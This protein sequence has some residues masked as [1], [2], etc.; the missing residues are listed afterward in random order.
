M[1]IITAFR[2]FS[3]RVRGLIVLSASQWVVAAML[4]TISVVAVHWGS[5]TGMVWDPRSGVIWNVV[6]DGPAD[7]AGIREG[8]RLAAVDDEPITSGLPPFYDVAPWSN[9]DL[10]VERDGR[11][12]H[13]DLQTLTQMEMRQRGFSEGSALALRSANEYIRIAVNIWILLLSGAILYLR[14][15]HAQARVASVA[16][17]Y[18]VGGNALLEVPGFGHLVAPL[19]DPLVLAIHFIDIVFFTGFLALFVHF[20]LIFPQPLPAV[21]QHK[22]IQ[23]VP[24]LIALPVVALS[25]FR[26]LRVVE[27]EVRAMLPAIQIDALMRIYSPGMLLASISIL[28]LH[29]RHEP[30]ET[31]R[32]RLRWVLSAQIPPFASWVLLLSLEAVQPGVG[33]VAIGRTIFWVGVAAGSLIFV[34]AILKHR[35]FETRILLR[36]SLQ[37]AL[38]RGT[39]LLITALPLALL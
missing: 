10:L 27:P 39:L 38:A 28:A 23:I 19:P 37:Y 31:D 12:I 17:A 5:A 14:P 15:G 22:A 25:T 36:K 1:R 3:L 20:A 32:R 6:P 11:L 16:L 7:Q 2:S 35:I 34:W 33:T 9:A 30:L 13:L 4:F 8:E 21:R 18:W 29:F 24:Y 26:L